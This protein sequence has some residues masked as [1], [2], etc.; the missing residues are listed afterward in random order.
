[1]LLPSSCVNNNVACSTKMK[2]K[3]MHVLT[4]SE[5]LAICS[6]GAPRIHCTVFLL[7][8]AWKLVLKDGEQDVLEWI[9]R[10]SL[11]MK[12]AHAQRWRATCVRMDVKEA[13]SMKEDSCPQMM[14]TKMCLDG[15][16]RRSWVWC[17]MR[18]DEG[19]LL[20][21]MWKKVALPWH[22]SGEV[23]TTK[24]CL[25]GMWRSSMTPDASCAT[26]M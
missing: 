21:W 24:M 13:S 7:A 11:P 16:W 19:D 22:W 17:L 18:K 15:M 9:W 1:L 20:E 14:T 2:N 25:D 8:V 26:M 6:R 4:R 23:M 3:R 12:P 10:R 5:A